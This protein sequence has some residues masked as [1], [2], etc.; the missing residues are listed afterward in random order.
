MLLLACV[1]G[2]IFCRNKFGCGGRSCFTESEGFPQRTW[3]Y[4]DSIMRA[5]MCN[6]QDFKIAGG[7]GPFLEILVV[8]EV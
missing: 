3:D 1:L 5:M 6:A 4:V 7:L 2:D 8:F